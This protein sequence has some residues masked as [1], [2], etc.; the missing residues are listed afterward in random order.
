MKINVEIDLDSQFLEDGTTYLD[1]ILDHAARQL[2]LQVAGKRDDYHWV[3]SF[4]TKVNGIT[5]ELVRAEVVPIV[6]AELKNVSFVPRNRYGDADGPETGIKG[7]IAT[8]VK[9]ELK[10]DHGRYGSGESTYTKFVKDEIRG[11][12]RKELNDAIADARKKVVEAVREQ[13]TDII[14]QTITKLAKV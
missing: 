11:A 10:H 9:E 3:D 6:Q 2:L 7:F 13:A 1:S 4:Q 8:V 12:L 14:E 5:D